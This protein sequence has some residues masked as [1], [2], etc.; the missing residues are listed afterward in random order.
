M[1]Y[2]TLIREAQ[3][4]Y[5]TAKKRLFLLDYDG[6]LAQL[7]KTPQAAAPTRDILDLLN[8]LLGD[9]R[10]TVAIVTGRSRDTLDDWFKGLPLV[11]TAEH[12][13]AWREHGQEWRAVDVDVSW[14]PEARRF[15][16]ETAALAPPTFIEEKAASLAWHYGLAENPDDVPKLLDDL[17]ERLTPLAQT[18]G[19]TLV[20]GIKVLE[21]R[22]AHVHKGQGAARWLALQNWDFI[23]AAGDEPTDE[24]MF[25]A[26]PEGAL[27]IKIGEGESRA[28]NRLANPAEF[29]EFLA[30]LA[31]A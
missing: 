20:R 2:M 18:A 1:S 12:G 17:V 3:E 7:A 4:A 30:S 5:K 29:R 31:D 23:L 28:N 13:V 14:K 6:T 21:A 11:F 8:H 10:N 19:L 25:A 16:Q 27:T 26:M 24:D 22:P 9:P 15:M